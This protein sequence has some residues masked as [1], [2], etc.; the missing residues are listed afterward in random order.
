MLKIES[1]KMVKGFT[2]N[3]PAV[4]PSLGLTFWFS[5]HKRT[6]VFIFIFNKIGITSF[7]GVHGKMTYVETL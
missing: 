7:S 2:Q 6:Q 3:N 4:A 5:N 1:I